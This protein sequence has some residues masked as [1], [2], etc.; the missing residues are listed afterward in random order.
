MTQYIFRFRPLIVLVLSSVSITYS[1]DFISLNSLSE[2]KDNNKVKKI[3][4]PMTNANIQLMQEQ[5]EQ[6][7]K[8]QPLHKH[9]ET[10][11]LELKVKYEEK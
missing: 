8:Y 1:S 9:N 6:E 4:R 10:G 2:S 7:P 11:I 3:Y 5:D